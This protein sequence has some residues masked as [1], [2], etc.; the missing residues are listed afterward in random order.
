MKKLRA[1]IIKKKKKWVMLAIH[2]VGPDA[3]K[4]LGTAIV[5]RDE[6]GDFWIEI[7]EKGEMQSVALKPEDV[8]RLRIRPK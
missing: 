1:T 5:D 4:Y 2:A 7:R 6:D 3:S 8:R